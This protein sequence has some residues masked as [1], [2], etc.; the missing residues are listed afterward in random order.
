M[1]QL[2]KVCQ[3]SKTVNI[4]KGALLSMLNRHPTLVGFFGAKVTSESN[5]V[6]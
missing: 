4:D 6:S 1:S 5:P 3:L 2:L